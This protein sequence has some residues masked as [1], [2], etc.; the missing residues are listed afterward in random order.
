MPSQ[1]GILKTVDCSYQLVASREKEKKLR[2]KV[3]ETVKKK[4]NGIRDHAYAFTV[5]VTGTFGN[6]KMTDIQLAFRSIRQ[7]GMCLEP[8]FP[9][10]DIWLCILPMQGRQAELS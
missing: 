2:G 9:M 3:A 7:R 5:H 8:V 1:K 10:V 6:C 4:M